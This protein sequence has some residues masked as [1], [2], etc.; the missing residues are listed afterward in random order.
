MSFYIDWALNM[1]DKSTMLS[2]FFFLF[3]NSLRFVECDNKRHKS[4]GW[5]IIKL[6]K[7]ADKKKQKD[8][9]GALNKQSFSLDAVRK[10]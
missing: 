4:A 1:S 3:V 8:F 7:K 10:I 6:K 2:H 9:K 5:F